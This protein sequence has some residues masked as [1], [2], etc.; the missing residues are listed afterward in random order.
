M[1]FDPKGV[2]HIPLSNY[3]FA[4]DE[5]TL[6]IRLRVSKNNVKEVS[7]YYGDTASR[8]PLVNFIEVKMSEAGSDDSFT[9]FECLIK[10]CFQR[11][12]YYFE[13]LDLENKKHLYYADNFYK[14]VSENRNDLYKFPYIRKEDIGK[15]PSWLSKTIFYNIF[16]DSF[17]SRKKKGNK[18]LKIDDYEI[19]N[20]LGGTIKDIINKLDYIKEI[21]FNGV[22]INP[23][24]MANE[25]HKYDVI[26]YFKIDP[27]FGTN[28]DFKRLVEEVHKKDMKLV[29]D[30]VLNHCG[31]Y[32]FAFDDVIKKQENSPYK[33]WFY[34]LHFPIYRPNSWEEIPPYEA[35]GYERNMPKLNTD[36]E[37]VI[38]YFKKLVKTLLIDFKV[39]GFRLDTSDEVNDYFWISLNREI[40]KINKEAVLIGEIWEN[41]EHW[42]N[43]LMFDSAMNYELRKSLILFFEENIDVEEFKNQLVRLY[44][45][46]KKQY[47]YSLLN[48]LST[49]D[50]AR[51]YSL[52]NENNYKYKAA[53]TLLYFLPG[54]LSVLYGEEAPIKGIKESDYR[55]AI[56][57]RKKLRFASFFKEINCIRKE[58]S[59]LSEGDISFE[60][61]KGLLKV[62]RKDEKNK[63]SLILSGK[64]GKSLNIDNSRII[65]SSNYS[66][67]NHKLNPFGVII[68]S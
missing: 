60:N 57:F 22:Y 42:L 18:V 53:Y 7:L 34:G 68:L 52:V 15:P 26:D 41:P 47:T 4:L 1:R 59:V 12:V 50:T 64:H 8:T 20:K 33:D 36:N 66:F 3:A 58:N 19:K 11:V 10:N 29:I 67:K 35:F 54:S 16:P 62:E 65:Y 38:N 24:F 25:Y 49:H 2:L 51:F 30:L 45:R 48:I 44:Y 46:N 9:Y 28:K 40:K 63:L 14:E 31:W 13:I 6:C 61:I 39:D 55:Q 23:L 56:N 37:E 5:K 21:G 32:F 27:L 43:S 17:L